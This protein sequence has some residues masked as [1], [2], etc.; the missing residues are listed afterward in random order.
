M[1]SLLH[2]SN[3]NVPTPPSHMMSATG[4]YSWEWEQLRRLRRRMSWPLYGGVA[5]FVLVPVDNYF[6]N[7][8]HL[9]PLLMLV[10]AV[11]I[12]TVF[13]TLMEYKYWPCPR[14]G[15][16]FHHRSSGLH[17]LIN[18]FVNRCVTCG[19]PKWAMSDPDQKLKQYYDPFRTDVVFKLGGSKRNI[20]W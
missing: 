10:W 18:P 12:Y 1:R 6:D 20:K 8:L 9:G 4:E 16:A 5:V 19:L 2:F 14:C 7:K 3:D 13:V 11:S 17:N 15:E